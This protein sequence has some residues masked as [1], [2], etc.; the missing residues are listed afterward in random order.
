MDDAMSFCRPSG[1]RFSGQLLKT[2]DYPWHVSSGTWQLDVMS[3]LVSNLSY[4]GI[5]KKS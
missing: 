1:L 3:V 4:L 2:C 5:V